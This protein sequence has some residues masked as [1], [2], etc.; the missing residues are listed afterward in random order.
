MTNKSWHDR[1]IYGLDISTCIYT[2]EKETSPHIYISQQMIH[3]QPFKHHASR[4]L[5]ILELD[6]NLP[7]PWTFRPG[8]TGDTW[9][10]HSHHLHLHESMYIYIYIAYT[11]HQIKFQSEFQSIQKP[12]GFFQDRYTIIIT[13]IDIHYIPNYNSWTFDTLSGDHHS[14]HLRKIIWTSRWQSPSPNSFGREPCRPP[15]RSEQDPTRESQGRSSSAT[16]LG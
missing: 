16:R 6:I 12:S 4:A 13:K 5:A 11:F 9:K 7:R 14:L 1:H 8:A 2:N 15:G 3:L 10:S